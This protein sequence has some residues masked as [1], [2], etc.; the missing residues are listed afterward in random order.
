M[1]RGQL[2]AFGKNEWRTGEFRMTVDVDSFIGHR[3]E[4]GLEAFPGCEIN[5][6]L[7]QALNPR[8]LRHG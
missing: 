6:D 2:F 4:S 1:G 5:I 3:L 8:D 7:C